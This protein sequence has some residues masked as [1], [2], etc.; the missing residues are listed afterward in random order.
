MFT[1]ACQSLCQVKCRAFENHIREKFSGELSPY[2]QELDEVVS[3][4]T[5]RQRVRIRLR[6]PADPGPS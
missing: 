6:D 2:L 5:L 4:E 1:R 3:I